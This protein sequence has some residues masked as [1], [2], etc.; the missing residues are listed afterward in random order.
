[1]GSEKWWRTAQQIKD[2]YKARQAGWEEVPKGQRTAD[3]GGARFRLVGGP[4]HDQMVRMYAPWEELV[5]G[6]GSRYTM[7]PPIRK[8]GHFVYVYDP[9]VESE[10]TDDTE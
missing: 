6:D 7:G 3:F 4:F 1:M 10:E 8:N 9:I 2:F 5:F